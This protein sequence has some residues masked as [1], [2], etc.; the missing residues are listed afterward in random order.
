MIVILDNGHGADTPGKRSPV[1]KDGSQLFEYEFNRDVVKRITLQLHSMGIPYRILVPE[2]TDVSLGERVR[3]ANAIY[4]QDK[5]SFILSIHANA[6]G[7]TGWE[8]HTSP[9]TTKS[10]EYSAIFYAEA[11]NFFGKDWKIRKG[12]VDPADPDWDSNLYILTKSRCPAVLTEN[13]FMD[14]PDDCAYIM[15]SDGRQTIANMHV[16]AIKRIYSNRSV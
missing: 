8:A 12:S 14:T 11:E 7:G 10:D 1:W 9:G 3:R 2:S 4:D 5:D 16:D 13:F 6:G 15:S